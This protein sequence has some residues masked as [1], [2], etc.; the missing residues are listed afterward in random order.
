MGTEL[1]GMEIDRIAKGFWYAGTER[2]R[3]LRKYVEE[4][5]AKEPVTKAPLY[6]DILYKIDELLKNGN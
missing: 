2:L 6:I 3:E 4:R 1:R 5:K